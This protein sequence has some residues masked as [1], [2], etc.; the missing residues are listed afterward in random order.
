M[1]HYPHFLCR[2][3]P[4]VHFC[5]SFLCILCTYAI[6]CIY[7]YLFLY[8]FIKLPTGQHPLDD[9]RPSHISYIQ[10]WSLFFLHSSSSVS[11][12]S[13]Q[14]SVNGITIYSTTWTRHLGI[15]IRRPGLVSFPHSS[16]SGCWFHILKIL[17]MSPFPHFHHRCQALFQACMTFSW[18]YVAVF[19]LSLGSTKAESGTKAG[20]QVYL[21]TLSRGVGMKKQKEE[22]PTQSALPSWPPPQNTLAQSCGNFPSVLWKEEALIAQLPFQ[23]FKGGAV[24]RGCS[25]GHQ[26]PGNSRPHLALPNLRNPWCRK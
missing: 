8:L 23:L 14:L 11:L 25:H 10:T 21:G 12:F 4:N 22:K 26:V 16:W 3:S 18:I 15:I 2:C 17:W 9:L 13:L 6:L 24:D 19:S 1:N 5:S 7:V 20:V